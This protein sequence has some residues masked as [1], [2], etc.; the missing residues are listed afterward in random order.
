M[1]YQLSD[2]KWGS[3]QLGSQS[4]ALT[5]SADFSGLNFDKSKYQE[6]DFRVALNKAF[7]TWERVADVDFE[8]S[9]SGS[10]DIE[11]GVEALAGST[12]GLAAVSYSNRSGMDRINSADIT[13]DAE[14]SWSPMG[15]TSGQNFFAVAL[16]EIGHAF[17]LGHINDR[18][19]IM[20]PV[21]SADQ[22]GEGDIAGA[23]ALYG[24]D[25]DDVSVMPDIDDLDGDVPIGNEGEPDD[26]PDKPTPEIDDADDGGGGLIA[27]L[28]GGLL[29]LFAGLAGAGGAV[30]GV[31]MMAVGAGG[32][33][34]PPVEAEPYVGTG[35]TLEDV[36]PTYEFVDH[37]A[38]CECGC[39]TEIVEEDGGFQVV[40]QLFA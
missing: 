12:I 40:H 8:K 23:Q 14:E 28:I 22:L 21:I 29:A 1:G 31:L 33:D 6:A 27:L 5:V 16:H 10:A 13:F 18:T 4:G 26:T 20:N 9:N 32:N 11:I 17:G 36:G 34:D 24:A 3:N 35:T 37:A 30:A 39:Q 15:V 19:Q 25:D 2:F 7:D 38:G